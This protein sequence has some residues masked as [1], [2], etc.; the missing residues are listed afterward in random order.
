MRHALARV[1]PALLAFAALAQ[2]QQLLLPADMAQL[3]PGTATAT[4]RSTAFRFQMM[5]DN[6]LFTS[7]GVNG[8]ITISRLRFRAEDGEAN[9][10]GQVYSNVDVRLGA[11]PTSAAT[12][13]SVTASAVSNF[14]ILLQTTSLV[15]S[16]FASGTTDPQRCF[17][18]VG[19][20]G[21]N[22][23]V[24][25][26]I[27]G[28]TTSTITVSATF[29][30][31]PANGD[32][33]DVVRAPITYTNMAQAWSANIAGAAG[34][35]QSVATVA[36]APAA[37]TVPN[38][39]VI[40]LALT[41]GA[42]T[43]DPTTMGN[44]V[45]EITSPTAPAPSAS[46]IV[47]FATSAFAAN[48]ARRLAQA[49]TTSATGLLT[50]FASVVLLDFAGPGGAAD[51]TLPA[52]VTSLGAGCGAQSPNV[53]QYFGFEDFDLRG[54]NKSLRLSPDNAAAPTRY[55]VTAG[56]T[57]VDLSKAT[58]VAV[59]SD[60]GIT[61]ATLATAGWSGPFRFP[62]G[63]TP[64]LAACANG[65]VWLAANT[66]ADF[67]PTV[68]EWLG[69]GATPLPARMAPFWHD[70]HA[71][72]NLATNPASGMYVATD[73][74]GGPGNAVTYV[75]WR[76]VGEFN[77]V[78]ATGGHAV[79]TLQAAFFEATQEVEFRYGAMSGCRWGTGIT[80]FSRGSAGGVDVADSGSRDLSHE[81]PVTSAPA[82]PASAL[83]LAAS[84][85]PALGATLAFTAANLPAEP[86][87]GVFVL[88][89]LALQPG[90]PVPGLTE[91]GCILTTPLTPAASLEAVLP[92][93]ATVASAPLV[94][95]ANPA[96]AGFAL[97][98]QFAFVRTTFTAFTS[99]ALKLVV[100]N[101]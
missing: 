71:G 56:T 18:L 60:D 24:S 63:S 96:L 70:F 90:L 10:G 97:Y 6:S 51:A 28:N 75:T 16:E 65:Y 53:A 17:T 48:K 45:V 35:S 31:A 1:V 4:W 47:P 34:S 84:D 12:V 30:T 5:Y 69:G 9:L 76:E 57:A 29:P 19:T 8:P 25:R 94:I 27:S 88:D 78:S 58:G 81:L 26:V 52:S 83:A 59:T 44:L 20:S 13:R 67:S 22:L 79:N 41:T 38:D 7:R 99:N 3:A 61:S 21:A 95:P 91:P 33:F 42:F 11:S 39:Y 43:Y 40:D 37:G 2:A 101:R 77:T 73:T 50:D 85:R 72:R 74:S 89:L 32:T 82:G 93:G 86:G 49:N 23:G 64:T 54:P 66:T 80:G 15:T 87:I 100:G 98:A 55:T 68:A 14:T 46:S 62:G 36:V 92:A